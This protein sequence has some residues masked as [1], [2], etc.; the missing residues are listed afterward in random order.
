MACLGVHFAL[1]EGQVRQLLEAASDEERSL[2]IHEIEEEGLEKPDAQE[3][4]IAWDAIHRCLSD[5]TLEPGGGSYPLNKA[6][7]GGQDLYEG[8][9]YI[10]TLVMPDEVKDVAAALA[11]LD[12]NWLR[13]RYSALAST[14]YEGFLSDDDFMGTWDWFEPL[15]EFYQ[16]AAASGR[17]VIFTVSQ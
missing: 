8:D 9:E 11:P 10:I 12:R 17:A 14:D 6:V 4:G 5:G 13:A 7:L 1:T 2:I 16:R 15:K 3:T